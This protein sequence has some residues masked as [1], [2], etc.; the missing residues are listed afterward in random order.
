MKIIYS[1]VLCAL[2]ATVAHAQ[3]IPQACTLEANVLDACHDDLQRVDRAWGNHNSL[4]R[5]TDMVRGVRANIQKIGAEKQAKFC[6]TGLSKLVSGFGNVTMAAS[7]QNIQFSDRCG[8]AMVQ[9]TSYVQNLPK[10]DAATTGTSESHQAQLEQHNAITA[11][12]WARDAKERRADF[13]TAYDS[14]TQK[15]SLVAAACPD[16]VL[17]KQLPPASAPTKPVVL[18]A[19]KQCGYAVSY[20]PESDDAQVV[21]DRMEIDGWMGYCTTPLGTVTS[22]TRAPKS[23]AAAAMGK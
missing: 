7:L 16:V 12:Q 15:L 8:L 2:T 21:F 4:P 6:D 11:S 18:F 20:W 1:F 19:S 14:A 10:A 13:D 23:A 5:G 17:L 3:D 22:C 9:A